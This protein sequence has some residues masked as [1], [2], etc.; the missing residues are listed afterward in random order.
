MTATAAQERPDVAPA[1]ETDCHF[2]W[3]ART[4]EETCAA[5][6][7]SPDGLRHDEA[8]RRLLAHGPNELP[9]AA[10]PH[11]FRRFL[12]QFNNALI[13]FLLSATLVAT[14]L[15]HAIDGAVVAIVVL[16]NAVVGFLQEG[17]AER[18]LD[19]I[20]DMI[21]P[22][23][24][25]VRDGERQTVDARM[26]VPGDIVVLDAGD[27]VPADIRLIRARG[28]SAD[29]AILTGESVPAEKREETVAADAALGDRLPILHSGTL[30]TTGQ[31][32]GVVVAT[33][34]RTEIGRISS[35]IGNAQTLTTP[36][37]HQI[38]KFGR[39]FTWYAIGMAALVFI[40]AVS[41]R[42]YDWIDA[43]MV[44]VALAV[45]VVPEGL[46]AVITITLAIG[47]R[48]MAGL[49]AVV[50]RLPAVETWAPPR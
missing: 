7:S 8:A 24:V 9:A 35:L 32:Q 23:T 42:G 29:E 34:A 5:L 22:H 33:G 48:R 49:N 27:K 37:L 41:T 12:A 26:I 13:Y 30:V 38:N 6:G 17:K 46:P 18:A 15:G 44:V 28:L 4:K 47:V 45:G 31:G 19:A 10:R 3:H 50:R 39:L 14:V 2:G 16:V 20:R 43:L 11:P 36:L 21:A 25:V 1:G 40:F